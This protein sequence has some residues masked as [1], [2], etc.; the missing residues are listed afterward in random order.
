MTT[1]E[2][3]SVGAKQGGGQRRR[4]PVWH[5]LRNAY[6]D[7]AKGVSPQRAFDFHTI[8]SHI[9]DDSR[10]HQRIR[11]A[12]A[13]CQRNAIL[14]IQSASQPAIKLEYQWQPVSQRA[15][16]IRALPDGTVD[17]SAGAP[18]RA[19]AFPVP[20]DW[21]AQMTLLERRFPAE[22]G[23]QQPQQTAEAVIE[24]LKAVASL[25]AGAPAELAVRKPKALPP[26]E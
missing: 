11:T 24:V 10:I 16:E 9:R 5:R 4:L 1:T 8:P 6:A 19:R 23:Q 2:Q 14:T 22:W 15:P 12:E 17:Q 20:G 13:I 3:K 21:K 26:P 18:V 25:R 7:I